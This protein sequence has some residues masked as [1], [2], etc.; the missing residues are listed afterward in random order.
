[1]GLQR[2]Y[3]TFRNW[4]WTWRWEVISWGQSAIF[5]FFSST[6]DGSKDSALLMLLLSSL[7]EAS[8]LYIKNFILSYVDAMV[9]EIE[10][11]GKS[12]YYHKNAQVL[13]LEGSKSILRLSHIRTRLI[14]FPPTR[15]C[16]VIVSFVQLIMF[17]GIRFW[18][19][20]NDYF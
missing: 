3:L 16:F 2:L 20:T 17:L 18:L 12:G 13:F 11:D 1:M 14:G 10:E 9:P 7:A 19:P 15:R 5:W 6:P 8:L 4:W